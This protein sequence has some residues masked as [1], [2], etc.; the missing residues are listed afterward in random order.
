MSTEENALEALSPKSQA[1]QDRR[2]SV[3]S[4]NTNDSLNEDATYSFN[5]DLFEAYVR[6]YYVNSAENSNLNFDHY[7]QSALKLISQFPKKEF[8]KEKIEKKKISLSTPSRNKK[9]LILDLDETLVH[10]DIDFN[11]K[12]HDDILKFIREDTNEEILIPL[13]LRPHLFD[14]LNF[15]SEH[16]ELVI[17]TASEKNYADAIIDYIEK[18]K[19]YFSRRLYRNNCIYLHPCLYIKDLSLVSNRNVKDIVIVDNSIFSFANNLSNGILISSFFNDKN[20]SML[21][22]LSSYLTYLINA[23]DVRTVNK[24]NF[25][26]EFYLNEIAKENSST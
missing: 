2:E 5:E 21:L 15:A 22:N 4:K 6:K 12:F 20:D 23:E 18:E 9:T 3:S 17:F 26:F 1:S 14:F 25:Q 24:E 10:A 19:K 16:F 11:F 7:I 8:F 13:L